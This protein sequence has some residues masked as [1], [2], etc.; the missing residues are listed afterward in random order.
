MLVDADVGADAR[1]ALLLHARLNLTPHGLAQLP[2]TTTGCGFETM[3]PAMGKAIEVCEFR[4]LTEEKN[5]PHYATLPSKLST[6]V[7]GL[8]L[9]DARGPYG[10]PS[11]VLSCSFLLGAIDEAFGKG[12]S[13]QQRQHITERY[14]AFHRKCGAAMKCARAHAESDAHR[15]PS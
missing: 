2:G 11:L 1:R 10:T 12:F 3:T 6:E 14:I 9:L 7:G 5:K 15:Q 8:L 4:K 13:E